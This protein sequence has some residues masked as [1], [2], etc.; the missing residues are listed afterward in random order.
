M[1]KS[2]GRRSRKDVTVIRALFVS[3]VIFVVFFRLKDKSEP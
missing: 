1:K 2:I 3:F